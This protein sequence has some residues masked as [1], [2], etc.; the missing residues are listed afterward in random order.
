MKNNENGKKSAAI[1]SPAVAF[2]DVSGQSSKKHFKIIYHSKDKFT[3]KLKQLEKELSLIPKE[4]IKMILCGI[5]TS[6][7]T[8]NFYNISVTDRAMTNR[9]LKNNI[10]HRTIIFNSTVYFDHFITA[11]RT[12]EVNRIKD[13]LL[14]RI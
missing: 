7:I 4:T 3:R 12:R 11:V 6:S 14:N 9:T 13:V 5:D 1:N 2:S 8:K 10:I